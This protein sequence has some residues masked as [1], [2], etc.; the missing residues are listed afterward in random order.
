MARRGRPRKV[1]ARRHPSGK[2]V[3]ESVGPTPETLAKLQPDFL[4][5]NLGMGSSAYKAAIEIRDAYRW[6]TRP[7]AMQLKD[8]M[9]AGGGGVTVSD[10]PWYVDRYTEWC[11]VMDRRRIPIGPVLDY[12]VE[13]LPCTP[14]RGRCVALGLDLYAELQGWA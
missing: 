5:T 8:Y 14:E 10:P 4:A 1:A 12:V 3:H 6:I 9:A 13:E 7:V 11:D 2:V